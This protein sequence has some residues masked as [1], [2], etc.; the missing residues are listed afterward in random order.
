VI[1]ERVAH[2]TYQWHDIVGNIGVII[3]IATYLGLQLKKICADDLWFSIWNLIGAVLV[4]VS[5][6]YNWNLSAFIIE[7][8]W[9]FSSLVGVYFHF[10]HKKLK[11]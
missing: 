1:F 10:R 3:I 8:F 6:L 7:I 5:V 11:Q 4:L 2:M 9:I